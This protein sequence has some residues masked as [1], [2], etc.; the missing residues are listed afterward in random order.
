MIF[1]DNI[2]CDKKFLITGASSGIGADIALKLNKLGAQVIAIGKNRDKLAAQKEKSSSPEKFIILSKDLSKYKKLDSWV[3]ELSKKYNGFNGAVLSAGISKTLSIKMP[4]YIE[5][6]YQIFNINYFGNLQVL[7][8][9][10][11]NRSK[12]KE[13]SS[14]IWI[15]SKASREPLKGL[16]LYGASKA[17]IDAT[18]KALSQEIYPRYRI[19]SILP[20]LIKTPMIDHIMHS[21]SINRLY[22]NL[23][24]MGS[25]EDVSNLTCFLLSENAKHIN[26]QN[27]IL[28]NKIT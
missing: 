12:T 25:V 19:N 10:L 15:S 9:L 4:N 2:F 8:G 26:G 27:I 3:L 21:Q 28:D 20:G 6:G 1:K 23:K 14:F 13:N 22:S 24:H 16:S 5:I 18:V 7:K 11:D 17:A